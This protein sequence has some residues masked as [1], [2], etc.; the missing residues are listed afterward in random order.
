MTISFRELKNTTSLFT[1]YLYSPEKTTSF[2][3]ANPSDQKA[4][5]DTFSEVLKKYKT[6]TTFFMKKR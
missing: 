3:S 4:W 6:N 1:D 5:S 2:F